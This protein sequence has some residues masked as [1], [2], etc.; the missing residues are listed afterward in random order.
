[1]SDTKKNSKQKEPGLH[2]LKREAWDFEGCF[3]PLL[4]D[5]TDERADF[6]YRAFMYEYARST[7]A[8]VKAY[9]AQ[10]HSLQKHEGVWRCYLVVPKEGQIDPNECF[11]YLDF[12]YFDPKFLDHKDLPDFEFD[13][14]IAPVGFP[15]KPFI[16]TDFAS[17]KDSPYPKELPRPKPLSNIRLQGTD[18]IDETM[19]PAKPDEVAMFRILWNFSDVTL[20]GEFERWLKDHRPHVPVEGRGKNRGRELERDLKALGAWRVM[21]HN[22]QDVTLA[23]QYCQKQGRKVNYERDD[24]W[25]IAYRRAQEI[26]E[27]FASRIICG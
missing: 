8:L 24:D 22:G 1:M 16:D 5:T 6:L 26:L 13:E 19:R 12:D 15:D 2:E 14:L 23:R 3:Y 25:R 21:E 17:Y 9:K 4:H 10:E 7:P 18:W 27:D 20:R 11:P